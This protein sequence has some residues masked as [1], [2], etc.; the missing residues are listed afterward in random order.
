VVSFFESVVRDHSKDH[1]V[2]VTR[3][4]ATRSPP[5]P[6]TTLLDSTCRAAP[7]AYLRAGNYE[8]IHL[9]VLPGAL[10]RSSA[11]PGSHVLLLLS[12]FDRVT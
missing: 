8:L 4:G 2:A 6:Y 3:I 11:R 5:N 10:G 12:Q 9:V 7:E 1:A